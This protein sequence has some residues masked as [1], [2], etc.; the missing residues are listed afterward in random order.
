MFACLTAVDGPRSSLT[1]VVQN[2]DVIDATRKSDGQLVAMKTIKKGSQELQISRFLSS[3]QHDANHCVPIIDVLDDPLNPSMSLMVM[4]YLRPWDDP[5]LTM[6]G[7]VV[8]FVSQML[9]VRCF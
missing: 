1:S 9:E 2:T 4:Q 5:E 3:V 7:D 8:D 6:V